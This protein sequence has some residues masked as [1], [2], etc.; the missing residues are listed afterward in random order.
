MSKKQS[1]Q[2]QPEQGTFTLPIME[3][4]K[5]SLGAGGLLIFQRGAEG[6]SN[7][8]LAVLNG[9][10]NWKEFCATAARFCDVEPPTRKPRKKKEENAE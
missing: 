5:V 6:S 3:T 1:Q 10:Q 7:Y 4:V 8:Q 9:Q 2:Q